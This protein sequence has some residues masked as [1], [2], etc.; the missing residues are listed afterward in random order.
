VDPVYGPW[1]YSTEFPI[2]NNS[3]IPKIPGAQEWSRRCTEVTESSGIV[4]ACSS[5]FY[6]A[7]RGAQAAGNEADEALQ[8]LA[9]VLF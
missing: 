9:V 7:E 6:R 2:K 4:V 8:W 1:T 3:L 5:T